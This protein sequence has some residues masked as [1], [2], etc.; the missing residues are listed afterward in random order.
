RCLCSPPSLLHPPS[1]QRPRPS[2]IG[3]HIYSD[4]S[5]LRQGLLELAVNLYYLFHPFA[6]FPHP[7]ISNVSIRDLYRPISFRVRRWDMAFPDSHGHRRAC[8]TIRR[9]VPDLAPSSSI[10][11]PA[12]LACCSTQPPLNND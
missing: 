7:L 11:S 2:T 3:R 8:Y 12:F 9:S 1:H 5:L 10:P 6:L 4:W